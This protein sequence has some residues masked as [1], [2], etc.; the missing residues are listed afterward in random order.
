MK[1]STGGQGADGPRRWIVTWD[2]WV[3]VPL[4]VTIL[5]V[6]VVGSVGLFDGL[7]DGAREAA[8]LAPFVTVLVGI[9]AGLVAWRSHVHR[10]RAD[11][12]AEFWRRLQF[13]L[14]LLMTDDDPVRRN[15]GIALVT[16]LREDSSFLA[17]DV[18]LL[19]TTVETVM[20]AAEQQAAGGVRVLPEQE[21]H[22][23]ESPGEI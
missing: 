19:L 1:A 22:D 23:V 2:P 11:S 18:D 9:L 12:R 20:L 8:P 15:T 17:E 5:G 10:R 4:L 16:S 21:P 13:T 3:A 14:D 6:T 7:V